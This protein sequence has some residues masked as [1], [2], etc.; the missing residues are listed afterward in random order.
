MLK[1]M[2]WLLFIAGAVGIAGAALLASHGS[3]QGYNLL[4]ASLPLVF[5]W[6]LCLLIGLMLAFVD[7][8]RIKQK[9]EG[10]SQ[11]PS[12]PEMQAKVIHRE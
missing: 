1:I 5:A 9:K 6:G 10:L 8:Q 11:A 7:R 12:S 2:N 4:I 3:G